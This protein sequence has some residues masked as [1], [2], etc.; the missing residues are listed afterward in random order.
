MNFWVAATAAGAGYLAKYWQKLLG[1]GSSSYQM[2][3]NEEVGSMDHPFHRTKRRTK[4]HGDILAADREVSNGRDSVRSRFNVASTSGLDFEKTENLGN[5]REYDGLPVSNFPLELSLSYLNDHMTDQLPCSSSSELSCFQP[6]MSK[7]GPLRHKHSNQRFIQP[8]SSL[9]SCVLSDLYKDHIEMEEYILH[10]FQSASKS[11]IRRFVVKDGTRIGKDFRDSFRVQVD[12][13]A[14]NFYKEPFTEKNKDVYGIPLL[15]K[16]QSLKTAEMLD[17]NGGGRQCGASSASQMDN[18]KLARAKDRVI[19]FYLRISI[20]LISSF[21]AKKREIDELK[22]LLKDTEN[23]VQ[24]LQEELEMRDTLLTVK[25]LS[26]EN[27]ESL[28]IPENSLFSMKEQNLVPSAK[29][30]DKELFIQSAEEGSE[31]LSKI[32]AELEAELQRLGLNIDTSSTDKGFYDLH[33]LDQEITEDFSE[34]VLWADMMNDLNPKF[35]QNQDASKITSSGN[36]TVSPWELSV[37]LHEVIQSRLEARVREL[38]IALEDSE[39]RLQCI[40][41]EQID[42]R[43]EFTQSEMLHSSSEESLTSQP[44]DMNLSGEALDAYNEAYHELIDMDDSEEELVHSPSPVDEGKHPQSHTATIGRPFSYPN[45]RTNG[46]MSLGRVP[47]KEKTKVCH[48]KIGTMKDH[49]SLGQQTNG[50]DD[51]SSDYDDEML[52]KQIVEKTRMGSPVVLNAQRWLFSMDKDDEG[53]KWNTTYKNS[54][55]LPILNNR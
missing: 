20:G 28:G 31:S 50:V 36:Y 40:E 39:S 22:E 37:R 27:C 53:F 1:D 26:N 11:T 48:K 54:P 6:T 7:I 30:D 12:L 5:Y 55:P 2:S 38:E 23:L 42:S 47:V 34:G 25:E 16:R 13:D 3:T 29:S 18:E 10:S 52:I 21:M 9:E 51:E 8:L 44:L 49:F 15:P 4:T 32:E 41:A 14:S 35:Q 45:G 24:D 43:K 33:E 17:I 19:L 46:S